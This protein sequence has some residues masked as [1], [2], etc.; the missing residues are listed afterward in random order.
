MPKILDRY[1]EAV[2]APVN[3]QF[4]RTPDDPAGYIRRHLNAYV[5][6]QGGF[7]K[8]IL[9]V[10]DGLIIYAAAHEE[11]YDSKIAEDRYL[12]EQWLDALRGLRGLLNGQ[13]GRL[14]GGFLDGGM[15]NLHREA[16]FEGEL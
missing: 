2:A 3:E 7:E 1:I 6:P 13:L 12:G 10:L 5:D 16:G 14:D 4:A 11:Q 9:G 8:G 15:C